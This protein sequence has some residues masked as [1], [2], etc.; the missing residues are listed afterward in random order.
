MLKARIKINWGVAV[1][2][3]CATVAATMVSA[4]FS[5]AAPGSPNTP[6]AP[7]ALFFEDFENR[8]AG[9]NMELNTYTGTQGMTYT[10]DPYW[11]TRGNC[12]GFVVD[13]TSTRNAADCIVESTPT[14]ADGAFA[15]VQTMSTALGIL[16]NS[17]TP[18]ANAAVGGYTHLG[19]SESDNQNLIQFATAQ[20]VTL[21]T[22]NRFVTFS[23]DTAARSCGIAN[24]DPLLQ[25]Y[26]K[27]GTTETPLSSNVIN[28]CTDS[29][30]KEI[31]VGGSAVRIGTLTSDAS[32]LYAEPFRLI[33]R[34]ETL[35]S[36]LTNA[37]GNDSALDNI[38]IFD[39]SPQLDKSFNPTRVPVGETS[40]LTITVTNTAELASK[41]GWGFTDNLPEGLVVADK[42]EIGGTCTATKSAAS[43]D[44]K[45]KVTAGRLESGQKSCTIE[46]NVTSSEGIDPGDSKSYDNGPTNFSDVIGLDLPNVATVEFYNT[47][48]APATGVWVKFRTPLLTL[49]AGVLVAT[50]VVMLTRQRKTARK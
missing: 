50:M 34:N 32:F 30:L 36:H 5:S 21:P 15:A 9:S 48:D 18:T 33:M 26:K 40:R 2:L 44:T 13:S 31:T 39:V 11:I 20:N 22:T 7:A 37:A 42:P 38:A 46:L 25:F 8:S 23:V 10:A 49:F 4:N 12:N 14:Y 41:I 19:S 27:V 28:A 6:G 24:K 16:R 1:A 45:V 29:R 35:N 3:V 43:R 47:P 17:P